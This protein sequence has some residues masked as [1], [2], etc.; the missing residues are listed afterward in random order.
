MEP[1]GLMIRFVEAIV[2]AVC[3]SASIW[4]VGRHSRRVDQPASYRGVGAAT[5]YSWQAWSRWNGVIL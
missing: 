3:F 4:L 2:V 1:A 5:N